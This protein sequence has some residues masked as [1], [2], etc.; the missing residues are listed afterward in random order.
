MRTTRQTAPIK[1]A[2]A[3]A[4]YLFGRPSGDL[5]DINV[6][7]ALAYDQH[8][9][10]QQALHYWQ[11]SLADDTQRFWFCRVTMLGFIRLLCQPTVMQGDARSL[12]QAWGMYSQFLQLPC[13]TQM[14]EPNE[15]DQT[16]QALILPDLHP[17]HLTDAY[18]FSLASSRG[19]RLVSFDKVFQQFPGCHAGNFLRLS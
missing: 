14:T 13:V 15:L 17:R 10:H 4:N 19:L 2:E 12:K 18:L 8:T 9:H 1:A 7:L 16:L 3:P 11:E 6:W 5:P